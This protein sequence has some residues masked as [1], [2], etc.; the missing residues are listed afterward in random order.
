MG[1]SVHGWT[2]RLFSLECG[3]LTPLCF[4][5]NCVFSQGEGQSR[6][7]AAIKEVTQLKKPKTEAWRS[8]AT[9]AVDR[10]DLLGENIVELKYW[11]SHEK[12]PSERIYLL[13]QEFGRKGVTYAA[14]LTSKGWLPPFNIYVRES[15]HDKASNIIEHL[16]TRD[17]VPTPPQVIGEEPDPKLR[18][19]L[20]RIEPE[21]LPD[22]LKDDSWEFAIL[23]KY[24]SHHNL[25]YQALIFHNK[26]NTM[27]GIREWHGPGAPLMLGKMAGRIVADK[28][29]RDSLV[30]DEP[31]IKD[32]WEALGKRRDYVSV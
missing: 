25:A 20:R 2:L 7:S 26:I 4:A 15:D 31:L 28:Q 17:T 19:H 6:S 14:E 8:R 30:S 9:H 3:G 1:R 29:F 23:Y 16:R 27:F 5:R 10:S 18:G 22:H 11:G 32:L 12:N 21:G 13:D 24:D